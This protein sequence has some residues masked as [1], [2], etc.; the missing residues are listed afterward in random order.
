M[1]IIEISRKKLDKFIG[2]WN[3]VGHILPTSSSARQ[4]I[5][6]IDSFEW[7]DGGYFLLHNSGLDLGDNKQHTL[8]VLSID[9]R[10]NHFLSQY[11]DN[12]GNSGQMQVTVMDD[13]WIFKGESMLFK[14][15]FSENETIFTI[16]AEQ[17]NKE[18][19][20]TPFMNIKLVKES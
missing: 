14:G 9:E 12:N 6:G 7:L 17:L 15:S 20:W 11:Y 8:Q 10:E 1:E 18:K 13:L 3:T 16:V 2:T 5:R 4:E 19:V